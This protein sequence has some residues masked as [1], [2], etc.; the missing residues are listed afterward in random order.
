MH[1]GLLS[2]RNPTTC[3]RPFCRSTAASSKPP[4]ASLSLPI[5]SRW[6]AR[7]GMSHYAPRAAIGKPLRLI[8]V[9]FHRRQADRSVRCDQRV[10]PYAPVKADAHTRFRDLTRKHAF[11]AQFLR[12]DALWSADRCDQREV[13]K[14]LIASAKG[15]GQHRTLRSHR[16]LQS[17]NPR[18]F[19]QPL[20]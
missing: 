2:S 11:H 5:V 18:I 8:S 9:S 13:G 3:P 10:G 12:S 19:A 17:F 7:M 6:F 16:R 4:Y 14:A 1:H 20:H 15:D